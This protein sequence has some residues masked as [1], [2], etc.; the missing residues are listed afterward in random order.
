L[1]I[2]TVP[3]TR[4]SDAEQELNDPSPTLGVANAFDSLEATMR[5]AT[6][7]GMAREIE[8]FARTQKMARTDAPA[9]PSTATNVP[10]P[11]RRDSHGA[12][13]AWSRRD[14][15]VFAAGITAAFVVAIGIV[16]L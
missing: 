8:G 1:Q 3:G 15:L 6:Q 10:N 9:D 4:R 2:D 12:A 11:R 5:L 14:R 13:A 16:L 7:T